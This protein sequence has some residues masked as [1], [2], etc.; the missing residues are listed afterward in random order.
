MCIRDRHGTQSSVCPL[1]LLLVEDRAVLVDQLGERL[2]EEIQP[3]GGA[4][5]LHA[6]SQH[7]T[8]ACEEALVQAI[9]TVVQLVERA[10]SLVT[11]EPVNITRE[12]EPRLQV[13]F[14]DSEALWRTFE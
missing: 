4:L 12:W 6:A 8:R 7:S 3:G 13:L 1:Q 10:D 14:P 5:L 9:K 2:S 11:V